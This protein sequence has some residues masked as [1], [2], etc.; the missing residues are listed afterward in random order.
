MESIEKDYNVAG[1]YKYGDME[2]KNIAG[3]IVAVIVLSV[4]MFLGCVEN[5]TST[6][7]K[8]PSATSIHTP[9][10]IITV[11]PKFVNLQDLEE[12]KIWKNKYIKGEGKLEEIS[13]IS[14]TNQISL[15]LSVPC[16]KCDNKYDEIKIIVIL[17]SFDERKIFDIGK[18]IIFEGI[19]SSI[20]DENKTITID[21]AKIIETKKEQQEGQYLQA[22][23]TLSNKPLNPPA[24]IWSKNYGDTGTDMIRS[25]VQTS[26]GG[27][28]AAGH[29]ESNVTRSYDIWVIKLD[30]NGNKKWDKV[31]GSY[32]Y[33][34]ATSIVQ[35]IDGGYVVLGETT[36]YGAGSYD[37][38]VIKLDR[39]GNKQWDRTFGG[40]DYDL[41]SF[42]IVQ[43]VDGGYVVLGQTKSYGSGDSNIWV[44]KLDPEGNKQWDKTY[45]GKTH[46]SAAGIAQTA[47]NGY[48]L[49]GKTVSGNV[50]AWVIKLTKDGKEQWNKTFGGIFVDGVNSIVQT[51]DGNYVIAGY[52]ESS[53]RSTDIWV[54]KL[55]RDGNILWE[56]TYGGQKNE[57]ASAIAQTSDG[58]YIVAGDT[59]SIGAGGLDAWLIKLDSDGNKQWD[60]TYGGEGEDFSWSIVQSTDG[61]Y[62]IA[63]YT[64][65]YSNGSADA[66]IFK[67]DSDK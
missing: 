16:G 50:D 18:T 2:K 24:D 66:W 42:S 38:W 29:I 1:Q 67:I 40:N 11:T 64:T 48:I 55:D 17:G 21:Q 7:I 53:T 62:A 10:P 39:N 4:V 31:F 45:G 20:S 41:P 8:R 51:F 35:T 63:G 28:M 58:G 13:I 27:Y 25:I 61:T 3:L 59:Y 32:G 23:N 33:E 9:T 30:N 37:I 26:D 15:T 19:L 12:I 49:G 52:K 60:K 54:I 36:S 22:N 46:E 6:S 47:D 65:S 57:L 43:T 14:Q 5:K 56:K 44:I 34:L